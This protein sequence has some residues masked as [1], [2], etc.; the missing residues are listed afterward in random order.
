MMQRR[1]LLAAAAAAPLLGGAGEGAEGDARAAMSPAQ[2]ALFETP[3]LASLRPPLRLDYEFRREEEGKEPVADTIRL[4]LRA[5]AGGGCCDVSPEFLT[6]PRA[7]RYP[8]APNFHGNPLLLFA[9]DRDTRELSAA[10]GST[11]T[12]FRNRF[13]QALATAAAVCP[14]EIEHEGRRVPATL[15]TLRPYEGEPRAG[16]YQHKLYAFTLSEAVP[17]QVQAIR[18]DL[19]ADGGAGA[20]VESISFAGTAPLAEG[21][22]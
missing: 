22:G 9:L 4:A 14:A 19:P 20:V 7:L 5:S 10:T 1:S 3:H 18:T 8:A 21:A 13:R 15:I 12:W 2:I 16:R 6:G 11:L 17:G